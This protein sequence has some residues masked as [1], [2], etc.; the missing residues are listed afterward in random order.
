MAAGS[1]F[2]GSSPRNRELGDEVSS[3]LNRIRN[4][5]DKRVRPNYGGKVATCNLTF[6]TLTFIMDDMSTFYCT[7]I[8]KT[9]GG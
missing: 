7:N 5:Y 6:S 9:A 1:R 8:Y 4:E 3:I 2:D